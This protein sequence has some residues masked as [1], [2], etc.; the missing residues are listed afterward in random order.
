MNTGLQD[1][2]N[3]AWKL[4]LFLRGLGNPPLLDSYSSE[5][6]PIIKSV[7]QTTHLLTR[8]MGTPSKFAQ[9]I[10]NAV[11]PMVSRLAPFQHAFVERLSELG[12]AYGESPIIEGPGKRY[13]DDS[14]RGGSGIG[15]KFL[16][17]AGEGEPLSFAKQNFQ[18]LSALI[19]VRPSRESGIQLVRPDGY[20]AYATHSGDVA[21]ALAAVQDLLKRQT[22]LPQIENIRASA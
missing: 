18:P 1:V 13:F 9:A 20:L 12:I 22:D 10:R 15:G 11:L 3:L 14:L 7:I 16:L 19:E 5:R 8:F 4:D 21:K 2:W 17:F 6:I